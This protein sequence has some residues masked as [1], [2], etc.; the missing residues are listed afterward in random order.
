MWKQWRGTDIRACPASAG[1]LQG[2]ILKLFFSM[3]LSLD[4]KKQPVMASIGYSESLGK[5]STK[6]VNNCVYW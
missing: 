6:F 2:K 5:N 3:P 1:N 4:N